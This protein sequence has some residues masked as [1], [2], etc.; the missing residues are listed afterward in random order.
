MKVVDEKG[1]ITFVTKK[2]NEGKAELA[3]REKAKADAAAKAK[4]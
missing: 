2:S 3:K 4:K 1:N